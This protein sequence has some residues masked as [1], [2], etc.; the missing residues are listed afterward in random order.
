[1]IQEHSLTCCGTFRAL[2][3]VAAFL[4]VG[5]MPALCQHSKEALDHG[6]SWSARG[7]FD[8][9]SEFGVLV[10]A[11]PVFTKYAFR[12]DPFLYSVGVLGAVAIPG[13]RYELTC[14]FYMPS[15]ANRW[16]LDF[17]SGVSTCQ[18]IEFYGFGGNTPR[19]QIKEDQGYYRVD[20]WMYNTR[21]FL[22]YGFSPS[23]WLGPLLTMN[24]VEM[25]DTRDRLINE[26]EGTELG[27]QRTHLGMGLQVYVDT[28]EGSL[29]PRSG[30]YV[31]TRAQSWLV[32][33]KGRMPY[34]RIETDVRWYNSPSSLSDVV[35]ALR[36][37]GIATFGTVPFYQAA[38]L[39]GRRS[40]RGYEFE[41]FRG[42]HSVSM[43]A[44][45]RFTLFR[46]LILLPFEFGGFLLGDAGRLWYGGESPGGLRSDAGFGL[47]GATFSRDILG[48]LYIAF[49]REKPVIR[50]GFG[51][52]Y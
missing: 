51:F 33:A 16:A 20:A 35:L 18:V 6:H 4:C 49:A 10:G 17:R 24:Y 30:I 39:G 23:T 41:R 19:D 34:R 42:D 36:L 26:I 48:V 7:A 37:G 27:S 45:V 3:A 12:A 29:Y 31:D 28:R 8:I 50:A 47:W 46:Q 9:T 11:G 52:D 2:A 13:Q 25:Y 21:L 15:V 38:T 5:T 14:D 44:E 40:M 1:L 32:P 43:S 22:G